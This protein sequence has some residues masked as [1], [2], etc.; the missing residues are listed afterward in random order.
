MCAARG[1]CAAN[2]CSYLDWIYV[3]NSEFWMLDGI[4]WI[5]IVKA[6]EHPT[7]KFSVR[8][9]DEEWFIKVEMLVGAAHTSL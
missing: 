1:M 2:R 3:G 4:G 6:P 7:G 8:L 5:V 9:S